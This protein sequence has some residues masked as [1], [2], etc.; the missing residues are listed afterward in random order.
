MK[1]LQFSALMFEIKF[2]KMF[3]ILRQIHFFVTSITT[4]SLAN[5]PDNAIFVSLCLYWHRPQKF[6][7]GQAQVVP[8]WYN[9]EGLKLETNAQVILMSLPV[10][11]FIVP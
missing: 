9:Y 5:I 2:V 7:T 3:D 11:V 4:F 10:S 8:T 1:C 6:D